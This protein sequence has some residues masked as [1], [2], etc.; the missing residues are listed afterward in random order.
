MGKISKGAKILVRGFGVISIRLLGENTADVRAVMFHVAAAL[1]GELAQSETR[2]LVDVE[3]GSNTI[4]LDTD[5]QV[6]EC[7]PL[8]IEALRR[9][10]VE[11][12]EAR[13]E[14]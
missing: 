9:C 2:L 1:Q 8:V 7:M 4:T 14:S 13:A 3:A 12:V 11:T 6:D 5:D 10:S